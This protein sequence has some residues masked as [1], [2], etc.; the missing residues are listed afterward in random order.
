MLLGS[1]R[2]Q[3]WGKLF[4]F[5]LIVLGVILELSGIDWITTLLQNVG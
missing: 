1:L 3:D 2:G 4:I 5:G